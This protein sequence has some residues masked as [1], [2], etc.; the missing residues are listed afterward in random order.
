MI[1]VTKATVTKASLRKL[2]ERK[3]LPKRTRMF[4][5]GSLLYDVLYAN[6]LHEVHRL[7]AS[8]YWVTVRSLDAKLMTITW[9]PHS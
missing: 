2:F 9:K 8:T 1:A 5:I 7:W 4:V 3:R 6:K